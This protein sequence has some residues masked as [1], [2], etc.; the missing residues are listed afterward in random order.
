[1]IQEGQI[2]LLHGTV[3][4]LAA[5]RLERIRSRLGQWISGGTAEESTA[6][7]AEGN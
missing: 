6:R 7:E 4:N 3:G 1:M 5:D 2:V